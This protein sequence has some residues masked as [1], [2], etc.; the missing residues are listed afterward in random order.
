MDIVTLNGK[1]LIKMLPLEACIGN[2]VRRI[3]KIIREVYMLELKNKTD[4]MD[5]Q[6]SL[7]K[8][9]TAEGDQQID[10]DTSTPFLKSALIEHISEL[11]TEL[12]NW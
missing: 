8:I 1:Y 11:E 4:E 6:E 2:I 9:L 5:P 7:H 3:L 12:D 10:F